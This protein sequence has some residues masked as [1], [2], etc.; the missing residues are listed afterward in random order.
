MPNKKYSKRNV[1]KITRSGSSLN[2]T[3]PVEFL[4]KLGW[5]EKQKVVLRLKGRSIVIRDWKG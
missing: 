5:K 4:A 1:R 2:I 3:L